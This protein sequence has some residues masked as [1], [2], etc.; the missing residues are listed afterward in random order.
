MGMTY[1]GVCTFRADRF[2]AGGTGAANRRGFGRTRNGSTASPPPPLPLSVARDERDVIGGRL[3]KRLR[4]ERE[5]ERER[6][7]ALE[8]EDGERTRERFREGERA[9]TGERETS[10]KRAT[11]RPHAAGARHAGPRR[12]GNGK[13]GRFPFL[14]HGDWA[15]PLETEI[16]DGTASLGAVPAPLGAVTGGAF[17]AGCRLPGF[18]DE[19]SPCLYAARR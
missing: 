12:I 4:S 5:R 16:L 8:R 10:R 13:P 7:S 2:G 19:S 9:P 6:V 15:Q 17:G 1:L 3:S 14:S 11:A 18:V